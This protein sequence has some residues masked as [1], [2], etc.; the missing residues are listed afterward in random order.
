MTVLNPDQFSLPG[1]EDHAES[2]ALA[3]ALAKGYTFSAEA[4]TSRPYPG[5]PEH[6]SGNVIVGHGP[7]DLDVAHLYWNAGN[8]RDFQ[9]P[10]GAVGMVETDV[11]HQR[12][13]L[14]EAMWDLARTGR[15]G[16]KV[17]HST[18]RS[19]EGDAYARGLQAKGKGGLVPK[20]DREKYRESLSLQ[21]RE[22]MGLMD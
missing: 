4:R 9:L 13:G 19:R 22:R 21:D 17:R 6:T 18:D 14:G 15:Y 1:M 3:H 12:Q 5:A 8:E 16:R 10:A 2:P 20:S 11:D 7:H